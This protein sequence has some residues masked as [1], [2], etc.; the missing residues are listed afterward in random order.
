M[1]GPSCQC[2]SC[3][4]LNVLVAAGACQRV[5]LPGGE[6]GVRRLV[7]DATAHALVAEHLARCN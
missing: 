4:A 6:W 7:D 5:L 1:H 2:P 3:Q